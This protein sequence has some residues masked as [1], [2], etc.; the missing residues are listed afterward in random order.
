MILVLFQLAAITAGLESWVGL[1]W[2]I[3]YPLGL[4]LAY[5][6]LLGTIVGIHG[7]VTAWQW[8][9][10]QARGLFFGPFLGIVVLRPPRNPLAQRLR[11]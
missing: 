11:V 7:A 4:F 5:M 3:A 8:T 10:L 9:W 6:L 1:H 2:T